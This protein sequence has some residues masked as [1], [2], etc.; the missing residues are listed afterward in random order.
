MRHYSSRRVAFKIRNAMFGKPSFVHYDSPKFPKPFGPVGSNTTSFVLKNG[1][2]RRK[3]RNFDFRTQRSKPLR[4]EKPENLT[5]VASA[6][7]VIL[8]LLL[9]TLFLTA[10]K[11][12][13]DAAGPSCFG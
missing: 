3:R 10:I 13:L 4:G 12:G 5:Q 7:R 2:R 11:L 8:R 9:R 1:M 6:L